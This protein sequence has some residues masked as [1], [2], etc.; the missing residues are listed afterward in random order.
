MGVRKPCAYLW[1]A[2]SLDPSLLGDFT[3]MEV[4]SMSFERAQELA[5]A[6]KQKNVTLRV[7]QL[8]CLALHFSKHLIP[9]NLDAFPEDMLL[10]F[11]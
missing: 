8:H 11:K 3:C 6:I 7:D 4:S 1:P 9:K 2:S 5:M 10:F